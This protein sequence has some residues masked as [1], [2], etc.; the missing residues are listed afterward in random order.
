MQEIPTTSTRFTLVHKDGY[1][2]D[3]EYNSAL[4]ILHLPLVTKMSKSVYA[5]MK[6][7]LLGFLPFLASV[8]HDFV[9]AGVPE[10]DELTKKLLVNLGFTYQGSSEGYD[11]YRKETF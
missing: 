1:Q 2:V 4:V 6:D 8:G 7:S 3:L 9:W 5:D 10:K 11:V